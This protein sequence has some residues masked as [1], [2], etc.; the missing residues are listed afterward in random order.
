LQELLCFP[1]R[2]LEEGDSICPAGNDV[3]MT[4]ADREPV[5]DD[6]KRLQTAALFRCRDVVKYRHFIV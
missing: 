2:E 5:A 4:I 3:A 6:K 1:T